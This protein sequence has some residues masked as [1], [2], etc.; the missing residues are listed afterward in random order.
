MA[1]ASPQPRDCAALP[2]DDILAHDLDSAGAGG[3]GAGA[4]RPRLSRARSS[5]QIGL[6]TL[7]LLDKA[8]RGKDGWKAVEKRFEQFALDGRLPKENFGKCIGMADFTEVA[9]ELFVALARRRNLEPGNGITLDEL[10]EFWEEMTDQNFDSRLRI[11][12]DMCDKSG[13]GKLTED[14][15]KEVFILSASADKLAKLKSH[16]AAYA[17]LIMEGLDPDDLGYIEI[18]QL[19]TLLF[20]GAVSIQEN[21]KF[22]KR[23][24][25]LARTMTPRRYRNPIKRCVTKTADFIHENWKR[26]WLISLWL[27][28]NVC[29]FIWKFEQYKQRAAFEVM[30]YCVC[31]AKGAA[32]TLKLN[33]ALILFPVCRNT[34]TRLRSTGLSKIIPFDDNINF[35]KVI[36]LAIVIGSLVH[37]LAHVTCNFLRLINCPQSKFMI[38]LGP[39]FN[40]HQPTY[41]SLL[42]S[43]PGVSGILMIVIMAFSFTLATHSFRR[44]VVKLPS[45]LHHLA[46]FNAFWYAH[47]LLPLLYVLLVVHPFF[48]FRKWYKKGTW[49]Y[50]AIPVLFYASERLIR[51]YREKNYRVRII[52]AAIYPGN[53]LSIYM[54]KPPGFK[55]KSGM[56]LFVKCPDV[57]SFEWHPFSL[58]SAQGDDYLSVHIRNTG[59]WTRKLR[60]LFAMVCEIPVTSKDGSLLRLKT[61]VADAGLEETSRRLPKLLI[62]GPYGAPAQDYKK[63]DILLLIGLGIGATPFISILKDLLNNI[64]SDEEMQRIHKPEI[65]NLKSN[66]RGR[67]YFHWVTREQGSFG[68]FKGVMDDVAESDHNHIIEMHNY[69]TS[70][71]FEDNERSALLAMAQELRHAKNGVNV[72]SESR[73][74]SHFGRPNWRKVFSNL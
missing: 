13:D 57:S 49:M 24:N 15:V 11:F 22:L 45:P 69:L 41:P 54:E 1:A 7:R 8:L 65:N 44:S 29:L 47:H 73:I 55:Y 32:E 34:L 6:W 33:M 26:I 20:R 9:G 51:K 48:I 40:Y 2:V 61:T 67:A 19:E 17:S 18:W 3:S 64:K 21:D 60:N 56:Y 66:V 37:T 28:L 4:G 50:L 74:R 68:W 10:K 59:D 62:D 53:V 38:T 46:G 70:V 35:H 27:T 71:Y 16:A 12:F 63:Y 43:A 39:N 30:G 23:M 5:A 72:V 25:S 31:I 42:A 52:K 58:T 14:E 36:A